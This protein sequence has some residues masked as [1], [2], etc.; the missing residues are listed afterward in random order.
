M[1]TLDFRRRRREAARVGDFDLPTA[2]D[3]H[4]SSMLGFA[5]NLLRDRALAEDCVQET[6][7]RAWRAREGFDPAR[8]PLR[9]WL[10]AIERNVIID[11]QRSLARMPTI[12]SN[13]VD[14]D[15]HGNRDSASDTVEKMRVAEALALLSPEHRQVVVAVH[16][17]GATYAE[18]AQSTGVPA[19]TLR[20]RSYYALRILRGHFESQEEG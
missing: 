11:V 9:T 10:F 18:L 5:V 14:D 7:L 15:I 8:G 16:L 6:F 17:A 12:A 2:F 1:I 13:Q 20:T 3:Q 19:G 4:A